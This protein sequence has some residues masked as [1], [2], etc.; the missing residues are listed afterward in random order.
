MSG[1]AALAFRDG[2]KV[3]PSLLALVWVV[4]VRAHARW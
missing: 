1:I 3:D 4:V 2:A